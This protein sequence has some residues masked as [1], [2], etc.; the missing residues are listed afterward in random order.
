[1]KL[2]QLVGKASQVFVFWATLL[3]SYGN[4]TLAELQDKN[5]AQ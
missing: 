4:I 5:N 2:I 3:H 1:M